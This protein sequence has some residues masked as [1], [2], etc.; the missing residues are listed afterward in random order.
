M[1]S[2]VAVL[3]AAAA[4]LYVA[5]AIAAVAFPGRE[6]LLAS[7]A[8]TVLAGLL[9]VIAG[10][11]LL[12]GH[13]AF[14][15]NLYRLYPLGMLQI[16]ADPLAGLF[17]LLIGALT[18]GTAVYSWGYMEKFSGTTVRM[19]GFLLALLLLSLDGI[20]LANDLALF[21]MAWE[22]MAILSYLLV[23]LEYQ[24]RGIADAGFLMLAMSQLG[25]AAFL[26][27]FLL[28]G[29]S[30]HGL[31]F[32]A[33]RLG[34]P[35]LS[36]A[37]RAGAFLLFFFGF[38]TKAGIIPLQVWLP[39]AHP[40][41]P[42]NISALL[43][44]VIV[45]MGVYGIVRFAVETV[46]VGP[47][48][49]GFVVAGIGS[50]SAILGILYALMERDIKR[51]LAYSTVENVGIILIGLGAAMVFASA[52]LRLL[53]A[54]AMV[55]ALFH[56]LNHATYKGL[57]FLGA[58]AID[59]AA[60]VRNMDRLGGLIKLMP[61]TAGLF[62]IGAL[63]IA[64]VPPFNG[65]ISEW[66]TLEALLQSFHIP[67]IASKVGLA[68]AGT[69]LA[70]T[71]GLA[72]T[73]FVKAYGISFLGMARTGEAEQAHEV[74]LSMRWGMAI[75]AAEA[76]VLGILPTTFIPWFARVA[77]STYGPNITPDVVPALYAHPAQYPLLVHL[78]G[79]LFQPIIPARGPI[80]LPVYASFSAVSPTYLAIS[81]LF[82]V[83]IV[84]LLVW[85]LTRLR[86]AHQAEV[87]A[88]G[89]ATFTPNY[90]YTSSSY[91]NPIRIIFGMIYRPGRQA[92]TQFQLS[93]YFRIS[94]QYRGYV[95]PFFEQHV[96]P[97]IIRSIT[98]LADG[99]KALQSGSVNLYLAYI[100]AIL[101]IILVAVR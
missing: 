51:F 93:Q 54:L 65:F 87:W 99:A 62:L 12:T 46:G 94:V 70:L 25:T 83:P 79:A 53:A 24:D 9:N 34:G 39:V 8:S 32:D 57:L 23:N 92:E 68:I 72:V 81:F 14:E 96:Y 30:V 3:L 56:T 49:W 74:P 66:L 88:G 19:Y 58:G 18:V 55:A 90:Q 97:T 10:A 48:W 47:A 69:F 64:A 101:I 4:C 20:V 11:S 100:F 82:G 36:G 22:S 80:I 89:I 59:H 2:S 40:A 77:A 15:V 42:S 95:V 84:G 26:A 50:L 38:G 76:V 52:Q 91:A 85:W 43:S 28:L 60:H 17:L 35:G 78:G 63:S 41:A 33:M 71:A 45:N 6:S 29:S 67:D 75:L 7:C 13:A 5:G 31:G 37:V 98:A 73:A 27:A 44:A 61:W 21:L 16:R 1:D 86:R